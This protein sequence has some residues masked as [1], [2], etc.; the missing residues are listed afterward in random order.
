M[1]FAV[2]LTTY[3]RKDG[4]SPFYLRRSLE[5]VT[6]QEHGDLDVFVVGDCYENEEEFVSIMKE[7]DDRFHYVNLDR[8]VERDRYPDNK[9][10]LWNAAGVTA[11]NTAS[12][13]AL[14]YGFDYVCHLDHDDYW[15]P[16]HLKLLNYGI[17]KTKA[18]FICTKSIYGEIVFPEDIV[19][20]IIPF[21]PKPYGIIN[22]ATCYNHR[23]IPLR[24]RDACLVCNKI[25]PSDA[26][27]WRRLSKYIVIAGLSSY[28]INEVTC[29]HDEEGYLKL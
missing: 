13:L 3:Q 27:L 2:S 25:I 4:K 28:L 24:Y 8:S 11:M 6:S 7:T 22:S 15:K 23:K 1:R 17:E 12:D 5:S 18:D 10:R 20:E 16:N 26:D 21:I 14:E 9:E 19:G 29:V